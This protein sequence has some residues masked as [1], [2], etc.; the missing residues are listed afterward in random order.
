MEMGRSYVFCNCTINIRA[1]NIPRQFREWWEK[2]EKD[3]LAFPECVRASTKIVKVGELRERKKN[4]GKTN[5]RIVKKITK[6]SDI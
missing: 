1:F 2:D 3:G 5:V 6:Q 4:G